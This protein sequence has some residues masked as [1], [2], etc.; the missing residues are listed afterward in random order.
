[1]G[2]MSDPK[3]ESP[4][5]MEKVFYMRESGTG[6]RYIKAM[7]VFVVD[8]LTDEQKQNL[9]AAEA[10]LLELAGG[11]ERRSS[12]DLRESAKAS[13]SFSLLIPTTS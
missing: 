2:K 5:E 1:M 13:E 8:K 6:D 12:S 9:V 7:H 3:K 11:H 4:L 10:V